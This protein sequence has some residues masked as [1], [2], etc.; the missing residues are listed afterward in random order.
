MQ[1]CGSDNDFMMSLCICVCRLLACFVD[2]VDGGWS[3][4]A[5]CSKA[6]GGGTYSRTCNDP[7]PAHGGKDCAGDATSACN[8][9]ACASM[10]C[11]GEGT[12]VFVLSLLVLG[13]RLCE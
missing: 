8:T 7:V 11:V 2:A 10:G 9:Q 1:S 5:A 13:F 12:R 4:F 3:R 6:C